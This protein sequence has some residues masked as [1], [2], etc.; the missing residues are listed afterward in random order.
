MSTK[1]ADVAL[2]FMPETRPGRF[3][4]VLG[5]FRR[6]IEAVAD[7]KAAADHYESLIARGMGPN[8]ASHIV[9]RT[10]FGK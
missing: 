2:D 6:M 9:F 5:S 8:Q 4:K 10:H 7:G 1:H 3:E